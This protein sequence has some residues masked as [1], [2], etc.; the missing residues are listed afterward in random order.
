MRKKSLPLLSL[1]L[2]ASLL[3][4]CGSVFDKEYVVVSDYT[5]PAQDSSSQEDKI[6]VRN[7]A[8]LQRAIL[9]LVSAG[10]K[11]G[12]VRFDASYEG[13][14]SADMASACWTVRTQDA[15]C[16]YCVENIAYDLSRIVSHYEASISI[17]YSAAALDAASIR[18]MQYATG[19]DELIRGAL[20]EGS[21]SL[22][23]LITSS[24]YSAEEMESRVSRVYRSYPGSVPT[25]P[26]VSVNMFSG[27]GRQRLYEI[28]LDY[29]LSDQELQ[30]RRAQLRALEPFA[31]E[32]LESLDAPRRALLA[33]R[34]LADHCTW[35]EEDG[36]SNVYA[37]LVG[38]A[39]NSEGMALAYV[40]L[41]QELD[42]NCQIVYG[43]FNWENHCWNI[44]EL[45]GAHYH[46]DV[47]MCRRQGME[48]GFLLRDEEAWA[49][50]R[51]DTSAYP[52]CTGAL[53]YP[54][55]LT[56]PTAQEEAEE[57]PQGEEMQNPS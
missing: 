46:V 53:R 30:H 56:P 24:F 1:L 28:N 7:L 35:T 16:A 34:Y 44:V 41:C 31:A 25:A 26:E 22:V 38:G 13:D 21:R 50:Y 47:G 23:L 39:A 3:S 36:L 18:Q 51:W 49:N 43:Q 14:V 6:T 37:A 15:L 55:L 2:A 5:P 8:Q 52:P 45:D 19:L 9:S 48:S 42:L 54:E 40:E 20:E 27:S 11:E 10:E 29:G 12:S 33:A 32:D 57:N 4:G 17:H